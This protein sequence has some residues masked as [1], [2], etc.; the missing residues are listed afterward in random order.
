[1]TRK[2]F[3]KIIEGNLTT[4][5][6]VYIQIAEHKSH[7]TLIEV[8]GELPASPQLLD[9]SH[10]WRTLYQCLSFGFRG[11]EFIEKVTNFSFNDFRV[12]TEELRYNFNCWL[13]SQGF[14]RIKEQILAHFNP[15]EEI[16]FIIQTDDIELRYLPWQTWDIFEFYPKIVVALSPFLHKGAESPTFHSSR[17]KV[18]ICAVLGNSQGIDIDKDRKLLNN[19]PNAE[20]NIL[21]E[22]SRREL[23]DSLWDEEGWD[24]LFFAGHSDSEADGQTGSIYI[25]K[26]EV[27]S[28]NNLKT[29]LKTATEHRLK[30]AIFNSCDGLGLAQS[31]VDLNIPL[32][33]VMREPVPDI[34]AHEFLKNFLVSF[35]NGKSL[36][37][38]FKEARERLEGLEDNFPF[39]SWL[40]V[41]F[42]NSTYLAPTWNDLCFGSFEVQ[43][44]V[45]KSCQSKELYNRKILLN[46]V[47][48]FWIKPILENLLQSQ[49]IIELNFEEHLDALNLPSR[50]AFETSQQYRRDLPSGTRAI[51][52]FNELN[53]KDKTIAGR[54][55]LI[56]G[57]PGS[58]KTITLLEIARD[59]VA[60]ACEDETL[61]VPVVLNLSSWGDFRGDFLGNKTFVDWLVQQI[62]IE[63]SI[64]KSQGKAWTKN[65]KL[66]LLLDGF[67]EVKEEKRLSCMIAINKFISENIKTEVIVCSRI[68]DYNTLS[69]RFEFQAAIYIQPLAREQIN[70]YLQLAG[71]KLAAVKTLLREDENLLSLVKNPLMLNVITIACQ[72]ICLTELQAINSVE[73][74]RNILFNN[75]INRMFER[76]NILQQYPKRN[77][78]N[79]LIWLAQRMKENFQSKLLIEQ[80]QPYWL[81]TTIQNFTYRFGVRFLF[82]IIAGLAIALHLSTQ[83]TSNL[84]SLNSLIKSSI[85]SG[86]I[87]ALTHGLKPGR[88]SG[89][90]C[91]LLY[92][93][94][95]FLMTWKNLSTQLLDDYV[96]FL[97]PLLIDGVT[98]GLLL[99][100]G[101]K[102]MNIQIVDTIKWSYYRALKFTKYGLSLGIFYT[103]I[104]LFFTDRYS[105]MYG[106]YSVLYGLLIFTLL[107]GIIGGLD[108]GKE[109][110]KTSLPNQGIVRS[111]KYSALFFAIFVPVGMISSIP[112]SE[113]NLHEVISIGLAVGLVAG[114]V[115]G[116]FSGLVLIKHLTLR[117][118]LWISGYIPWNYAKFL[119]YAAERILLQKSGGGYIFCHR[120]LLEYLASLERLNY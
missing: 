73:E 83:V 1:M 96:I 7:N 63:Y 79:Y 120:L 6:S 103:L 113:N 116:Q 31:L 84:V 114:L 62:F 105:G 94:I 25:N 107:P 9:I 104:H 72:G 46:K 88:F 50:I 108:K 89:V 81:Q 110:E 80:I 102:S 38:S 28:V 29:A 23:N 2:I 56:L 115:G 20:V 60:D 52:V 18:R 36:Y 21:F 30:I 35:S 106:L 86:V 42:Q 16:L 37:L 15:A 68:E 97:S 47:N 71:E 74:S 51:D 78:L 66:L 39:A 95:T 90:F 117:F 55:L 111:A 53:G 98:F 82:G 99:A 3:L 65:Q 32:V 119:D 93:L 76:R 14:L 43:Q 48:N 57:E 22:P 10:R 54:T 45:K 5:F 87:S 41:I 33:T 75:Y 17:N 112:F 34:V 85:I 100:S 11:F 26:K 24:I 64:P 12:L 58:G 4:G 67:D 92:I 70:G 101:F 13:N 118:I 109:I 77:S 59:L 49:L 40:P 19:L 44:R 8:R 27:L 61:P 91:A 69:E